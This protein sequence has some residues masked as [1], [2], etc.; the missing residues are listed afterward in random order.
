V[1]GEG[2]AEVGLI[3]DVKPFVVS[4]ACIRHRL[5]VVIFMGLTPLVCAV[6][7]GGS[8]AEPSGC[9]VVGNWEG[10]EERTRGCE[11]GS[12]EHEERRRSSWRKRVNVE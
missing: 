7:G 10:N 3:F 5:R 8:G 4:N 2:A 1:G 6:Y 12:S 11:K 9:D